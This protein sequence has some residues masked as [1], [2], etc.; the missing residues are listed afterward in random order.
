[1]NVVDATFDAA[2]GTWSSEHPDELHV[3]FD[4]PLT[5]NERTHLLGL[6]DGTFDNLEWQRNTPAH[7]CKKKTHGKLELGMW[8]ES[9]TCHDCGRDLIR[10]AGAADPEAW[11]CPQVHRHDKASALKAGDVLECGEKAAKS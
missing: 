1:M 9:P 11:V 3:T 7:L 2:K 5:D 4:R 8:R 6:L 10:P